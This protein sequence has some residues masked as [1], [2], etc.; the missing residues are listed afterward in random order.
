[1]VFCVREGWAQS[2]DPSKYH[3]SNVNTVNTL[4]NHTQAAAKHAADIEK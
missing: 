3:V 4:A 2:L 1:M